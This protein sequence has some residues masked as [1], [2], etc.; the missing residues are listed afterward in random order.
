M[1]PGTKGRK[2]GKR[3][4]EGLKFPLAAAGHKYYLCGMSVN[5][6]AYNKVIAELA[7][8][9][10]R[11]VAVSKVKP[12]SDIQALYDA[13]QRIFGENYVQELQEKQPILPADIEWHFIG[14][15][16][17]NKVKYIAPFVSMIHAVDSLRLLEEINKQ[18]AKHNRIIRCLL[19]VHIAEEETKFG[20]DEAELTELLTQLKDQSDK[21]KNIQIAGFMGMATNTDNMEQVRT[22]F[23]HLKTLQQQLK[24]TFALEGDQLTEL[25]IGMSGDY[26]IAL[27]EGSTMVRIGSMLFGAR[28]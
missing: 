5:L 11:L 3:S 18:A 7:P 6:P 24:A 12:A 1:P 25:S 14:H 26:T 15:L 21:F 20:L 4:V 13:G 16:Q 27:E 23:R 28:Y 19:Q 22:E 2:S 9:K 10:A 8:H 17:S